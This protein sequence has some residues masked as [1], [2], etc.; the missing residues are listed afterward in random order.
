MIH[1][2]RKEDKRITKGLRRCVSGSTGL[3]YAYCDHH[4]LFRLSL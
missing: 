1:T 4:G 3:L 2:Y